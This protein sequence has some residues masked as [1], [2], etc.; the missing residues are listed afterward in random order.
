MKF[1][2]MLL[3]LGLGMTA[4]GAKERQ[5]ADERARAAESEKS[6]ATYEKEDLQDALA[7]SIQ[8]KNFVWTMLEAYNQQSAASLCAELGFELPTNAELEELYAVKPKWKNFSVYTRDGGEK[9]ETY[10]VI[11]RRPIN[12]GKL[13]EVP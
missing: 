4:C 5:R 8:T 2:F 12:N 6:K 7:S 9:Q 11:C 1:K 13:P 10:Y 3:S